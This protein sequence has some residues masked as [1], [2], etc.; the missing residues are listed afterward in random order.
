VTRGG[1]GR[2]SRGVGWVAGAV[3]ALVTLPLWIVVLASFNPDP[4][5]TVPPSGFSLA[6]YANA[7]ARPTLL[8]SFRFSLL[9]AGLA[10][11][12]A[13]ATGVLAAFALVRFRFRGRDA[14]Q[15]ALMSPLIVPQVVLGMGFLILLSASGVYRSFPGL[16][17]LHY[18]LTV[19]YTVRVL[20]ASLQR[21]PLSLEEAAMSLGA[22]RLRAFWSVTLPVVRP[23]VIAAG[24]FAFVTSFDN[25]TASQFLVWDRTTL[26]VELYA[27]IRTENDPTPAA[28]SAILVLLTTGLV[29]AMDRWVGLETVTG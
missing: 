9:L 13:L 5:L 10:T 27:Y 19:P 25:F 20:S 28:V 21:F 18:V 2:P 8:A 22:T 26:P 3:L 24:I 7:L 11:G 16:L 6:W 23:G 1:S 4:T 12:L 14:F 15:A 29:L 17:L